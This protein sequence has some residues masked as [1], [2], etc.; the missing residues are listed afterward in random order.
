[1]RTHTKTTDLWWDDGEV[2]EEKRGNLSEISDLYS[3]WD[4]QVNEEDLH[5]S[6]AVHVG[7]LKIRATTR[8]WVSRQFYYYVQ[9]NVELNDSELFNKI[10]N[11]VLTSTLDHFPL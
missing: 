1:M 9:I 3:C 8:E 11:N 2:F 6:V 5:H 4:T 10:N 7:D